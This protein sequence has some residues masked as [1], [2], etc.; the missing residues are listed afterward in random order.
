MQGLGDLA[1]GVFFSDALDVS[2]NGSVVV[3]RSSTDFVGPD[4]VITEA[5]IWT[6]ADGMRHLQTVL[7][8]DFNLNLNGWTLES[9]NGVSDDGTVIVGEGT[10]PRGR[11]EAWRAFLGTPVAS[12]Q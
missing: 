10:N 5:F 7:E 1:G 3:G 6:Q 2:A 11:T 9:A 12:N 8:D 4:I